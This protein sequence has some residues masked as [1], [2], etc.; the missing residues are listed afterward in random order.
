MTKNILA[1]V[2]VMLLLNTTFAQIPE[3]VQSQLDTYFSEK[4]GAQEPGAAVLVVKDGKVILRKGYGVASMEDKKPV[5]PD[6]IFR[7][8]SV[9]KQ[10]TSTAILKLAQEGK[11]NLDDNITKYFP[12]FPVNGKTIT[13]RHLL[14]HTSGIKSYTGDNV[15]MAKRDQSITTNEML[16]AIKKYP[17]DFA[18]GDR[19]LY[20]NSG[21][22]MLG[23][24]IERV[25]GKSYN[26]Y[27]SKSLFKP[28]GMKNTFPNDEKLNATLAIGYSKASAETFEKA[29]YVHPTVPYAAG[30]IFSTVDDLWKWNQAVFTNKIVKQNLLEQAFAPTKLNDGSYNSYGFGWQLG[31]IGEKKVI[32]HGG[33]IDGYLSMEIF[34][35]E[36]SLYVCILSNSAT[37]NPEGY[38]Y[39]AASIVMGVKG[40]SPKPIAVSESKLKEYEGV[41]QIS[42]TEDR[43]IRVKGD[44]ITSQRTGGPVFQLYPIAADIFQFENSGSQLK[45]SRAADGSIKDVEL[46]G[47]DWVTQI[48]T[49]TNKALPADRI[50]MAL[51]HEI[52]DQ[53]VGE[54][55]LAPGFII[56]VWRDENSFKAQATGQP[57]FEIF[58][59]S[60]AM[61]FLKVVDAKIGFYKD[62]SGNIASMT[63]FQNGREIPGKKIK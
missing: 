10:F 40:N 18:P 1:S 21:Y 4:Y 29:T 20:N 31:R 5:S 13:V 49:R 41:Y 48:S 47:N 28:A 22:Y 33:A 55:E 30:S 7:I 44:K 14:N 57:A 45:F 63:L 9:T 56:K 51:A 46:I 3:T 43:V 16:E 62:D 38:A 34:V 32:G 6:M 15:L 23:I 27:I 2:L 11:L 35:P 17:F 60:E 42:S 50:E 61:F 58:A 12:D 53:Y 26:E 24:I 52:F 39:D 37:V 59:E 36:E 25:S 54:Y 19:W 8:G